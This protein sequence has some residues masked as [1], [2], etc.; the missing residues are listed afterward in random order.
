LNSLRI[1]AQIL[2]ARCKGT[3]DVAAKFNI[4]D[5]QPACK[6]KGSVKPARFH[7]VH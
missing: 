2:E 6:S 4:A 3:H 7:R 1:E 5:A